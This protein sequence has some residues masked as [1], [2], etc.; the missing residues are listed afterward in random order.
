MIRTQ[1][2]LRPEQH[3][4]LKNLAEREKTSTAEVIRRIIDDYLQKKRPKEDFM[5][6]VALGRSGLND[7]SEK[8]DLYMAGAVENKLKESFVR[9]KSS[10][11][12]QEEK[13]Q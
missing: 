5:K 4:A 9:E 6:I 7:V 10:A 3:R 11:K 12:E 1:I 8:H 2:Y 13:K